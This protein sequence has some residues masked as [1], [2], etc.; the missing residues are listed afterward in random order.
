MDS[1]AEVL[2]LA[3][4]LRELRQGLI[5]RTT[6]DSKFTWALNELLLECKAM[7]REANPTS[8]K[9]SPHWTPTP[10]LQPLTT[11]YYSSF[12]AHKHAKPAGRCAPKENDMLAGIREQKFIPR[13]T[14][15]DSFPT[16]HFMPPRRKPFIPKSNSAFDIGAEAAGTYTTTSRTSYL[17]HR[18]KPYVKALPPGSRPI[19]G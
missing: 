7:Q 11:T 9:P 13:T 6:K 17:P 12:Q 4:R 19:A 2:A 15:A 3:Q 18:V 8:Y 5:H 1:A 14:S 16:Q 10:D